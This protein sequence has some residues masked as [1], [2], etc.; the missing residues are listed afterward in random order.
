MKEDFTIRS[1]ENINLL[2]IFSKN[3]KN[4]EAMK[5]FSILFETPFKDE[6]YNCLSNQ[7][8][9][10]EWGSKLDL[11]KVFLTFFKNFYYFK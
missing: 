6:S 3:S 10:I 8:N 4:G 2:D 11:N 1:L 5:N 7:S 9:R